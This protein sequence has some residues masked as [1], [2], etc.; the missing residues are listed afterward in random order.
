LQFFADKLAAAP[1]DPVFAHFELV[2]DHLPDA[3]KDSIKQFPPGALQFEIG[4]QSFNPEVQTLVSRRQN[5]EK[6]AENLRWLREESHAHLH[7][8]LIAGLPGEDYDGFLKSLQVLASLEPDEIQIEPLKLLKG[9]KMREIAGR[10]NY[11][12]SGSPPYT[13]LGNPWLTFDDISRI[14]T[15]G[16]LLDLFRKHGGFVTSFTLL[17]KNL[18]F[19]A[20]LDRMARNVGNETLSGLSCRRVYELFARLAGLFPDGDRLPTLHDALFFDYCRTE[21]PLKGKLPLFVAERSDLC[22]WPAPGDVASRFDLPP[23]SRI[24]I[25]RYQFL[26]DYRET[27]WLNNPPPI[28]FVYVSAPGRGLKIIIP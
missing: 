23:D 16:R 13:I 20:V 14:E 17:L 5:N 26:R 4:I 3:L 7:V 27:P 9:T 15:I 18:P 22:V 11:H 8:D 21:M 6:A 19:A 28:T 12:F 24:K 25:F 1:D 10:E 2:P